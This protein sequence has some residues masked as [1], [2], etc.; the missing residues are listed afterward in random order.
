[1]NLQPIFEKILHTF[2]ISEGTS[3]QAEGS[4]VFQRLKTRAHSQFLIVV[5]SVIA[6]LNEILLVIFKSHFKL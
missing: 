6:S 3:K 1:M 5:K 4:K 2:Y